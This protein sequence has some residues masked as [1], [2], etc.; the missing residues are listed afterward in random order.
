MANNVENR[1]VGS[2]K[3]AFA[4]VVGTAFG[5]FLIK[6]IVPAFER[7]GAFLR[8]HVHDANDKAV[9]LIV[10]TFMVLSAIDHVILHILSRRRNSPTHTRLNGVTGEKEICPTC[11]SDLIDGECPNGHTIIRCSKCSAIMKDGVCP[12]GC[13]V[14]VKEYCPTCNCELIDGECPRGHT[15]VRCPG[16]GSILQEGECPKGC[17]VNVEYC[18]ICNSALVNNGECPR[19]HTIVRCPDCGSILVE[20][21]CPNGC[22]ADPLNLAWPGGSEKKLGAFALQVVTCPKSEG[23][24]FTLRVPISFVMGR[25]SVDAKEPF[26]EL[27]TI[28]RKEKAQCSR[29]YVRMDLDPDGAAFT[30][31]LLNSSRNPVFVN[32]TKIAHQ[33]ET[34]K[35][36]LGDH[37]KLN[38]GYELALVEA[39][40]D[41]CPTVSSITGSVPDPP[42]DIDVGMPDRVSN[43]CGKIDQ[44]TLIRE[45][46][47]G[48]F[49]VVFL[50][51]D[52]FSH[53]Q[54]ALR[55]VLREVRGNSDELDNLMEKFRLVQKLHHPNIA[56]ATAIHRVKEVRYRSDEI[57]EKL[58]LTPGD[59]VMIMRYAPGETLSRWRKKF[60]HG[61][62]PVDKAI[63]ICRQIADALDYAHG[64]NIIH[65]DIKP[66]NI[67]VNEKSGKLDV[68][69]LD[70]YL[71]A[72]IHSTVSYANM[73]TFDTSG[74][75]PYMAPEQWTGRKQDGRTDQYALAVVLYELVSG[76]VPFGYAFR[77]GD[78]GIMLHT[79]LHDPVLTV[80]TLS[81]VQ[82]RALRKALAKSAADR[83]PTCQAFLDAFED[84][85]QASSSPS[86]AMPDFQTT[87]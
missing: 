41:D 83:F 32:G 20:G 51:E 15:V 61:R 14:D 74:T 42:S 65:R 71:C 16:C 27:L 57:R 35:L 9:V 36:R 55:T 68:K 66:A 37:I 62:A 34:A 67:I 45:L 30:V 82:N 7:A 26:V 60:P 52:S 46:G 24:G 6:E 58:C 86:S 50:A 8:A 48:G 19:G 29:Q 81:E 75:R 25:S 23:A 78:V 28:T 47:S 33:N 38:P 40:E 84:E 13:R 31:T 69:V 63:E 43:A 85:E 5:A 87:F 80:N 53:A 17:C 77:Q 79:V 76:E 64:Q 21:V 72:E 73:S 39:L 22:N 44:Y 12:N 2:W 54:Y 49:G 18:P 10:V 56:A 59:P 4:L 11:D 1:A 3:I 70:F